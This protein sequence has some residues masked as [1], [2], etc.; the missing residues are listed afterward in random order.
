VHGKRHGQ[1]TYTYA[2]GSVY[3]GAWAA[4]VVRALSATL[5]PVTADMPSY[6]DS[7]KFICS[8]S[9]QEN[10]TTTRSTAKANPALRTGISTG[11]RVGV[12]DDKNVMYGE[13]GY[14][15]KTRPRAGTR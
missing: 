13:V 11:D 10:G 1:G 8:T 9:T 5:P 12:E 14:L 15:D 3:T 2:D 7:Y 6:I 4:W